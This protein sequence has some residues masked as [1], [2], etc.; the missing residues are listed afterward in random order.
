MHLNDLGLDCGMRDDLPDE[1]PGQY[2]DEII[3]YDYRSGR[4]FLDMLKGTGA[5]TPKAGYIKPAPRDF[6]KAVDSFDGEVSWHIVYGRLPAPTP[7]S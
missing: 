2:R 1:L 7:H 4:T 5:G 3:T 6:F